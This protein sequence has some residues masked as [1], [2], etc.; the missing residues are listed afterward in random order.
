MTFDELL[1]QLK[2]FPEIDL[3]EILEISS[4]DLVERFEDRIN[5][6]YDQLIHEFEE[7]TN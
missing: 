3:L 5:E 6:K 7:E 1:E 4:E 2:Q